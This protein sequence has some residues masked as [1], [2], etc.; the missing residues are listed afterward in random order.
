MAQ[1]ITVDQNRLTLTL[2]YHQGDDDMF[3]VTR[4]G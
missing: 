4:P 2:R 1:E 3:A